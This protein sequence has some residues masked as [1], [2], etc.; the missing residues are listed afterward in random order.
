MLHC[1][2]D[3]APPAVEF[4]TVKSVLLSPR[5]SNKVPAVPGVGVAVGVPVGVA[6][7]VAV[8]VGVGVGVPPPAVPTVKVAAETLP[9]SSA[10][11]SRNVIVHVPFACAAVN[12]LKAV[13]KLT[14]LAAPLPLC[15][16]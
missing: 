6:V 3:P 5:K 8:A 13:V 16:L 11:A 9:V 15:A 7:G 4:K 10:P 14:M 2:G 12:P 1:L